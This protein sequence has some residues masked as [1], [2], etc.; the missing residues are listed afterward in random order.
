MPVPNRIRPEYSGELPIHKRRE[1]IIRTVLENP[2]TVIAGETGSGKTTQIPKFLLECGFG[3]KGLI[4]CTQPRRV[5]AL[6]VANRIAEELKVPYGGPVGAKIRF[7][8]RTS[9]NTA[10]KVMTDGILLNE[11]QDDPELKRYEALVIDEA[12]ERSLNID[13]ILGL[14]RRLLPRRPDLKVLITSATID[15]E[16]FAR[17]FNNAP[18]LEVSGR[19]Y[20]VETHH[21]PVESILGEGSDG[22]WIE[23][24]AEVIHEILEDNRE[25]D[26][27]VFLPGERDI[28]ELRSLLEEGPARR[29]DLLPLYGRLANEDQQRIF[30]PGGRRRIILATNI[31]ETSITVPGI[32]FVVD[33][34]LARISRYSTHSRT[35]R[36]PIE[37]V[38]QSSANQ[39]KGRCGRVSN[40]I[41][42]RLFS[43]A[44]FLARPEFM[45]PEIHRSN[46]A[47]VI[48]RML[49][50]RLGDI[51]T[52]PF[53]DPPSEAAIR[54]GYRQLAE[55]GAIRSDSDRTDRAGGTRLTPIGRKLAKLPVDPTVGRMLLQ[56]HEENAVEAVLVIAA[57]L[58]IQDPRERPAEKAQE[59]DEMQKRFTHPNSDFLTLLNIWETYHDEMERLSQSRLRKFCR[60]HFLNYQRMREWRDTHHQLQRILKDL[61]LL[62]EKSSPSPASSKTDAGY[63]SIHRSIL[64]GLLSNVAVKESG[65]EYR[66]PR[67]RKAMLFPGS[68]LFD[69][70]AA[71][72]ERKAAYAKKAKPKTPDT[73]APEW[74]VCGEW[75]ETSRLF[76]RTAAKIEVDWIEDLAADQIQIKHSEPFWSEKSAAVLCRERHLL[77]GLE[78]SRKNVRYAGIEPGIATEIFVRNGLIE[79]GIKERPD[80]L[81]HNETLR[82][83]AESEVARL[84]SGSPAAVEE[85]LNHFYL[86]RL[87]DTGSFPDLRRFAGEHHDGSLD[88]LKARLK[89]LLPAKD[90]Q[91]E[92]TRFPRSVEI[93][94]S[95]LDLRYR[96][97]PGDEAHGVTLRVPL[98]QHEAIRQSALDWA[99]PGHLS[100]MTEQLLR[101][102]P[103]NIRRQLHPIKER[104]REIAGTLHPTDCPLVEELSAVLQRDYGIATR[105]TD[106]DQSLVSEHLRPRIEVENNNGELIAAG[107]DLENLKKQLATTTEKLVGGGL[108]T[109]PAWRQATAR[110]ERGPLTDWNFGDLPHAIDLSGEA[111][112][113]L[114]AYPALQSEKEGVQ[115]RLLPDESSAR[116]ATES[117]WIELGAQ[118]M[119]RE[120]AWL[121]RDLKELK[122]LGPLLLPLG[123]FPALQN[124]AWEHLKRHLFRCDPKLPLQEENFRSVLKRADEER[125][126][127]VTQLRDRLRELLEARQALTLLLEKKKT[128]RAIT[129]PGMREQLERIA[130][131]DFLAHYSFEELPHL[132]RYLKGMSIRAERARQ[133]IGKDMEKAERVAPW[134]DRL[135]KLA[136]RAAIPVFA[137][138]VKEYLLLLEEFKISVYAQELGTTRKVS[139]RRLDQLARKI[140]ADLE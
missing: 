1:D 74:I 75:M 26:I 104:A 89:D 40:G 29:C 54:G 30:H 48:L 137:E 95:S 35:Q 5:A 38:A 125:R 83:E 140:E 37:P 115:L 120:A 36:L 21:R 52:F 58:A 15:T 93:G 101:S 121:H 88:F 6:S 19:V 12:H 102:L 41:C 8:D 25:G 10:V 27:L 66:G 71:R 44:D 123:D 131:A 23:A 92:E 128:P 11:L 91:S 100:E 122:Q 107:R 134:A 116:A 49:A 46:L 20:P 2:V 136:K 109:L 118:V 90:L 87:H 86:E 53:I 62:P 76:A 127:L 3:Q 70:A 24:A 138:P 4:G 60:N 50:F 67:N 79:G 14:L 33:S 72:K 94:G 114:K 84:R 31:A 59:A 112:L 96:N 113:P 9:E 39:R 80:F 85:R 111:G 106:W 65:H 126:G 55:L 98:H 129:F 130:P 78:I 16:T 103:K 56:A 7:T 97:D 81:H 117:G 108:D 82:E 64:S 47:S 22:T 45:P 68:G 69:H 110:Y 61:R 18:I 73:A 51:Q 42:H 32:R 119:G 105:S 133:N 132:T 17:A 139:E 99:V 28:R 13:F 135:D 57:G 34:G 63:R 124:A 43:E 77:F